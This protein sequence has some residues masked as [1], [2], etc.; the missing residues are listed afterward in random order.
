MEKEYIEDIKSILSNNMSDK[1]YPLLKEQLAYMLDK[2]HL[3]FNEIQHYLMRKK[4]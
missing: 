4:L 3:L 2:T 1:F